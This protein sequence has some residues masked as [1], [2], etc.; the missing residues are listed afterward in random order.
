MTVGLLED[1][2]VLEAAIE[3]LVA[4]P[5]CRQHP[6]IRCRVAVLVGALDL[7]G[8]PHIAVVGLNVFAWREGVHKGVHKNLDIRPRAGGVWPL[9]PDQI[10]RKDVNPELVTEPGLGRTGGYVLLYDGSQG[11]HH[12]PLLQGVQEPHRRGLPKRQC[13]LQV[14]G[15]RDFPRSRGEGP[16]CRVEAS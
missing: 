14:Q 16:P 1:P 11:L 6:K 10:P 5:R 2:P 15:A 7:V 4:R 9:D 8:V 13:A 12:E 3:G